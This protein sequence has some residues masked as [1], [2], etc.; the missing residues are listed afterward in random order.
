MKFG[1]FLLACGIAFGQTT[2]ITP[3]PGDPIR[4]APAGP[5]GPPATF[6]GTYS[7]GT[8]YAAG[9]AVAYLGA[10]YV[11]LSGGN[12][13]N[14]PTSGAPWAVLAAAGSNGTNGTNGTN[15]STGPTGPTGPTGATGTTGSTGST[16][17]TGAT[18]PTGATGSAGP[19]GPTGPV[20]SS[21]ACAEN[22]YSS[23]STTGTCTH[24]LGTTPAIHKLWCQYVS[25]GTD[26]ATAFVAGTNSDTTA[27]VSG[28]GASTNCFVTSGGGGSGS[29]MSNPM[30]TTGDLIYASSGSTPA[31]LAIGTTNYVLTV[32]S[33]VPAWAANSAGFSDPLTTR[34][35]I[36]YRN[37]STTT[38]LPLGTAGKV[39]L[40]DGTDAVWTSISGDFTVNGSG[41]T[42]IGASKVTN[43]MLAGSIDLAAKVS[44]ILPGANGGTA[45]GFTALTG[46]TTSLK[47]F[48]LP[49]ASAVILTDNALVTAAQGGTANGFFAVSGP[50]SSTKT[51][52]FPNAS[53]VVLTDNALVTGAQGGTANGFFAVNGPAISLKTF[54]FPNASATMLTDNALVTGAQGGTGNGFFAVSGPTTSLRTFTFPNA[55]ATV[56]T[57]NA[58]VTVAQGGIGVATLTGIPRG[59]GTSAFT[60]AKADELEAS[61]FCSDAGSTD[62]YACSLSPAITAY[63]TGAHYRIVANT[64]NTGAA[65]ANLNSLGA[66]TIVK[67]AGGITTTLANNDIRAGQWIDLVYDG[68]NMQLQSTLGNATSGT[69]DVVGPSSATD[70]A[71]V[72][73]DTTTGKLV[74]DSAVTIDDSGNISTAGG[75]TLGSGTTA[76]GSLVAGNATGDTAASFFEANSGDAASNAEP[77]YLK[78][79]SSHSTKRKAS[80]F[81]CTNADGFFCI[82]TGTPVADASNIILTTDNTATLT[83][84]TYD[85]AGSGNSFSINGVAASANTG[86]GAV[87]RAAG[88]TFTTPTLGV[89]TATSLNGITFTT[90]TGTFTLTNAKVFAVTNSITLSGTDSTTMTFPTTSQTLLGL[91]QTNTGGASFK[92]NLAASTATD[93]LQTPSIAGAAPTAA[94]AIAYDTTNKNLHVGANSVDNIAGIFLASALPANNDCIK[95]SVASSVVR[96]VST[97]SACGAGGGGGGQSGWSG[98]PLTF[99]TT[100]TQYAPFVGGGMPSAT[101]TAVSTKASGAAT[102]SNLHVTIDAQLGAAATLTVT[103]EDGTATASALTCVTSSGG[104]SCDDTTHS[105]NVADADL[106]SWKLVSTGTVTAGLPQIKIAYAVGTSSVGVTSVGFTGGLISVATATTTPAFT[107]AGTSGGIPYFSAASTWAS[108]AA[109]ASGQFVLGGGAGAAPTATFSIVPVVNG[110]T[111]I[112]TAWARTIWTDS[113]GC[114]NATA[115]N[116]W[117]LPTTNAPT[118]TCYGTSLRFGALD[119]ADSA[120][121][122]AFFTFPLPT[123]WTGNIDFTAK[124]FVNATSQSVKLTIATIC[125]AVSEDILNPTFNGAQTVTVTSPG[126]ANQMFDFTQTSVTTTGCAAGEMMTIKVGRDVTDTSTATFSVKGAQVTLRVTPQA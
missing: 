93:S 14:T 24:N 84:K 31:R 78:L 51:F 126:T 75:E 70:N 76:G 28:L 109:L 40:S 3:N 91:N 123:G 96:L 97:G 104:T 18:G 16:G 119:Y 11:S 1:I 68:T 17:S 26:V 125:V 111:G 48:T 53:A 94:G 54:T 102:I 99:A 15:G 32:V 69:G 92:L 85:T 115:G 23:S 33:G 95:A 113:A 8:T 9:D 114:N 107:V 77:A 72:R 49:N 67:V 10:S 106:L 121:Q 47:T 63:V 118:P 62:A 80:L 56:L 6:R 34:G 98:L 22:P 105:V 103:L 7:A 25:D 39:M 45:N 36:I 42:A 19:T 82:A 66:K 12:V 122:S 116:S 29:G 43:T 86:T 64:A 83:N 20:G 41:V 27:W 38:R 90:S 46:P 37:A 4:I 120:N 58:V 60:V 112:G 74:Q 101:E 81:P 52:T 100:T 89:A 57:S 79:W 50:A 88:P 73:F 30:T 59:N 2:A 44:G 71:I 117:D 61:T 5:T 65:S 55:S 87:A 35:D 21:V 13:G 124:A 110:G 108:S